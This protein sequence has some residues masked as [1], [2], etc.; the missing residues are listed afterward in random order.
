[1][2]QQRAQ[3]CVPSLADAQQVGLAVAGVLRWHQNPI[4]ADIWR[5]FSKLL[6]SPTVAAS[7][8][9]VI[10]PIPVIFSSLRLSSLSR[11][12]ALDLGFEFC[13]LP[14]EVLQVLEQALDQQGK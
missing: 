4:Q 7:A 1:M 8:L 10:G 5:L 11:C 13:G 9:A 2:D 14:V 6:A 3:V 12:Q